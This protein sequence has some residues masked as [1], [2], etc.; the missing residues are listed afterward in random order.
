MII[1][2]LVQ[3]RPSLLACALAGSNFYSPSRALLF[4]EIEVNSLQRFQGLLELSSTPLT[5][6]NRESFKPFS[7]VRTISVRDV[8][9]WITPEILPRLLFLPLLA[10]FPDVKDFR[11]N[12]L[13][14]P[15]F[16]GAE[17]SPAASAVP[18][19]T[20]PHVGIEVGR[21]FGISRGI[22]ANEMFT[23]SRDFPSPEEWPTGSL[24]ALSLGNCR[25]PSLGWFLRYL[26]NF[27]D[28]KSLSL[29]DF[30][31]GSLGGADVDQS[32]FPQCLQPTLQSPGGLSELTLKIQQTPFVAC[33]P[34][35][36]FKYLSGSL[37]ILRLVHI[38]AFLAVG[39]F[40]VHVLEN[41]VYN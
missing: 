29:I 19:H 40:T 10:P 20:G 4:A 16:I 5:T 3:D 34:S 27:P 36:L 28:L 22:P 35:L 30:T 21:W 38:D 25:A 37:R 17:S 6:P 14:L 11:I 26:S 39:Q 33:V 12:S 31:W 9:A 18:L 2:F 8:D 15:G 32:T 41:G 24:E 1:G 13:T 23:N 7:S